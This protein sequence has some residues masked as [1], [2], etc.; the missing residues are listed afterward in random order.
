M[1]KKILVFFPTY[2]ETGNVERLILTVR[3]FLPECSILVVDDASPDGTGDLLDQLATT[4]PRLEIIHRPGKLG[5]G[6]AHKLAML[7]ARDSGFDALITMD[8]DF[9]HH[10]RYLPRFVELLEHAD[11]VTGSRYMSGG[12]SDYGIGRTFISRTANLFAK[13]AL[14]LALEENTTMYRAFKLALLER[15]PI[16]QIRSEGYSFAVDSLNQIAQVT[17]KLS[18]FPIHF[19]N[20]ATG[21]SKISE[22]EIYRAMFTIQRI[23]LGRLLPRRASP[24]IHTNDTIACVACGGTHHVQEFAPKREDRGIASDV[25]PY[26][27]ATHS[28]RSHG[29]ILR[30]LRCGLVFIRPELSHD[31]LVG[32]YES[33]VD[34]VYLEHIRARQTTFRRNLDQVRRHLRS[35]DRI[36][37]IGSYCGAFLKVARDAGLDIVGVEPSRWAAQASRG[38][39]SA[40]VVT[41]T[42]DALPPHLRTFDVVV[43]WDVLEHFADPVAELRRINEL[44]PDGG[45]LLFSTLMIDNWF[46]RLAGQYWPWLMDMHLFYFT[47]STIRQILRETGFELVDEGKYTHVVTLDYLLSK[48]GTLG[49]PGAAAL[50]KTVES[51]RLGRLEIP[52]RFGDIKLFVARK[53]AD[54]AP[55]SVVRS[56]VPAAADDDEASL[57]AE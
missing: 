35:V 19:E 1:L 51:S 48:L 8:A 37:E 45:T 29:P 3:Q 47:E 11:F 46:P 33:A 14:G 56:F 4:L 54:A 31:E 20:R 28:S 22:V 25:S 5:L 30:C 26:S 50:S 21:A 40:P 39:T 2:N 12:K 13:A 38:I 9:S 6:S 16:E 32:E 49:V 57:T 42:V 36:L 17:D 27:C 34:P 23:A 10:P 52:F 53:V 43:A 15:L 18:E 41:G 55:R 7:Y 44:L 24:V